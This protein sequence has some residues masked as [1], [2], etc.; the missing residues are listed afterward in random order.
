MKLSEMIEFLISLQY[1]TFEGA[2]ELSKKQLEYNE[3]MNNIIKFLGS[4][5]E[6]PDRENDPDCVS[7][8]CPVR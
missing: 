1:D 5:I 2:R 8:A 3:K 4:Y 7:G 6:R